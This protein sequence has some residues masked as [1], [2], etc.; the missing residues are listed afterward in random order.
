VTEQAFSNKDRGARNLWTLCNRTGMNGAELESITT[1]EPSMTSSENDPQL[2]MQIRALEQMRRNQ[3]GPAQKIALPPS[4]TLTSKVRAEWQLKGMTTD[5]LL[6]EVSA[7]QQRVH[8]ADLA[9]NVA[10]ENVSP[11]ERQIL[12]QLEDTGYSQWAEQF[13]TGHPTFVFVSKISED[14]YQKTLAQAFQ[15]AKQKASLLAAAAGAQLGD[16]RSLTDLSSALQGTDSE[17][18]STN[19][20]VWAAYYSR[21]SQTPTP[22]LS[23]SNEPEALGMQPTKV[24]YRV[25]VTATFGLK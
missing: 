10:G 6:L 9:G 18:W 3:G 20:Q 21:Y 8:E 4:V 1:G 2:Q 24:S 19:A 15:K 23:E 16:L 13:Q 7:L 22:T 14:E 11:E 17:D 25:S 5:E 12:Q